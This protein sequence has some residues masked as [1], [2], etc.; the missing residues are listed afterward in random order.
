MGMNDTEIRS[1][2]KGLHVV[3]GLFASCMIALVISLTHEDESWRS[4]CIIFFLAMMMMHFIVAVALGLLAGK[5]G[6]GGSSVGIAAFILTPL[7][8]PISYVRVVWWA[9]KALANSARGAMIR[10]DLGIDAVPTM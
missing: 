6:K 9:R 5:L 7:L 2:L 3:F 8:L 1:R 10:D 4:M